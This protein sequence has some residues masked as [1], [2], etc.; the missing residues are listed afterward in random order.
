MKIKK[1][2]RSRTAPEAGVPVEGVHGCQKLSGGVE[3]VTGVCAETPNGSG[4]GQQKK[5]H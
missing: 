1:K 5:K 3:L 2:G 4:V